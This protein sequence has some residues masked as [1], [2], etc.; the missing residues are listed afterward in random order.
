MSSFQLVKFNSLNSLPTDVEQV[1]LA[2]ATQPRGKFAYE[3]K[4]DRFKDLSSESLS[5]VAVFEDHICVISHKKSRSVRVYVKGIFQLSFPVDDRVIRFFISNG[6]IVVFDEMHR[7]T[8]FT[9][10]GVKL[11]TI[12]FR[13]SGYTALECCRVENNEIAFYFRNWWHKQGT[14]CIYGVNNGVLLHSY[15]FYKDEC[16]KCEDVY[17]SKYAFDSCLHFVL[18]Q[19]HHRLTGER[20]RYTQTTFDF[21][22]KIKSQVGFQTP[23]VKYKTELSPDNYVRF[24]FI[25]AISPGETIPMFSSL[26]RDL[27]KLSVP[28]EFF[29][30]K[31]LSSMYN[32]QGQVVFVR[33]SEPQLTITCFY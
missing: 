16:N 22:G 30:S 7:V 3:T 17:T 24:S 29:D 8:I 33:T 21:C 32:N 9:L 18:F 19:E 1:I 31:S 20:R 4:F 28:G 26:H 13:C 15:E 11:S 14:V 5:E 10:G 2:Y 27:W 25:G 12:S 6:H 23:A